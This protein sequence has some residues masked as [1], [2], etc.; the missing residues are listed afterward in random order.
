MTKTLNPSH[1]LIALDLLQI[2][3]EEL[4]LDELE[5]HIA[6]AGDAVLGLVGRMIENPY[7]SPLAAANIRRLE[8]RL[9]EQIQDARELIELRQLEAIAAEIERQELERET[10][11]PAKAPNRVRL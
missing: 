11:E 2:R 3:I 6:S 8:K 10:R 5:G 9:R 7:L 4:R 1:E